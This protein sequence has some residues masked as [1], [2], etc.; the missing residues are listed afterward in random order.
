MKIET[1]PITV[2]DAPD[3]P[4]LSFR[5]FR[6]PVDYP[7]MADIITGDNLADKIDEVITVENIEQ[8][9]KHIQ[10]SDPARDMLFVEIDGQPVGYGR[11]MW[12]EE[13]TGIYLYN[14]F[15]N[16]KAE[17]RLPGLGEAVVGYFMD[18]LQEISADHPA[19]A[20]K[21]FQGWTS[22][23]KPWYTSLLESHNFEIVRYGFEM[24]R[25]CSEPIEVSPLPEGIIV[26]TPT[27]EEY[28]KV[29]DA[30]TE[31][32]RDHW[33]FVEPTEESYKAW[34]DF[35]YFDASIWMVGWDGDEIVGMVQNFINTDEN[36]GL[37]RKRGYTENISVRRPWRR[38]GVAR[39]LLTRSI[40]MFQEMG[41][42]ETCLGV[43]T[44]NPNG[45]LQLYESVGYKEH[46]R[47]MNY[48]K[49]FD[50]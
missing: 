26:R 30:D 44:E 41:M 2:V 36:E 12:S 45:A 1:H 39:A 35:P 38:K 34:L 46:K 37:N 32:F 25:P 9:Y 15:L 22:N 42:E 40:K 21:Y 11:C 31:A 16:M 50:S 4:G 33:G 43:D 20:P 28:R 10:R 8:N 48:R 47:S 29:W 19:D 17:G 24:L 3:I 27:P 49:R 14:F 7:I 6:G 23:E 5:G 18:R 13:Q